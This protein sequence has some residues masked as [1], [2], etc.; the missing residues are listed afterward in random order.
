MWNGLGLSRLP[1]CN[2]RR[3]MRLLLLTIETRPVIGGV[4]VA[5][6][7]WAT[8]LAELGHEVCVLGLVNESFRTNVT[9]L[10]PRP[11][12][13]KWIFSPDRS[14][15]WVDRILPI[16][17]FRS[18]LYLAQRN[19]FLTRQVAAMV[20]GFKPDRVIF[21]FIN[22]LC[23]VALDSIQTMGIPCGAIAYAAELAPER[24]TNPRWLRKTLQKFEKIVAI[25]SYTKSLLCN[26][27]E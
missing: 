14:D 25:S 19:R 26:L 18:A 23:C 9:G 22:T 15:V 2:Y 16:R 5:I 24:V 21:C 12:S 20:Q 1:G 7:G 10:P 11:H 8:G 6:D 4:A 3:G 17:K 27:G 13:E